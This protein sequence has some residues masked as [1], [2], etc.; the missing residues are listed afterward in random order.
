[1]HLDAR[2]FAQATSEGLRLREYLALERCATTARQLGLRVSVGG[3]LGVGTLARLAALAEIEEVHVGSDALA[4]AVFTG[5][6]QAV[7]DL[8][9]DL[10]AAE[11][12]LGTAAGG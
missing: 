12:D 7:R 10:R 1:V 6:T 8:R 3:G 11:S 2:A 5:L 4:R 9:A